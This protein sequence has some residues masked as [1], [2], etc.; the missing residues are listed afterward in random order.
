VERLRVVAAVARDPGLARIELA[1]VG[2][3]MTE[4]A[5]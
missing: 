1:Y 3:N 5:T 2:F 4:H